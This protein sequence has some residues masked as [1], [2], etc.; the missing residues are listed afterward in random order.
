MKCIRCN[1]QEDIYFYNDRGIWYC[2]KC[3][4]FGRIN[5]GEKISKKKYIHK[6]YHCHYELDY[7]LTSYQKQVIV[8]LNRYLEK[9][10]D[11]LVY[12]ATGAGKTEIVM[13]SI[14][15]YLNQGKKVGIAISRRQV[16]L[17][18][19][20][21]MQK[22]FKELKVIA[23][24]EGHTRVTDADLI[25]CTMHQLYRYH[26]CFDLLIMDEVDAFPYRNNEVLKHIAMHACIGEVIYLSAT[27]DEEMLNDI[28]KGKL[29]V[30]K[31]FVRPHGY[32]LVVPKVM[33]KNKVI[34]WIY[35][36]QFLERN[37]KKKI[38]VLLFVPTIKL[39][40]LL[41]FYLRFRYKTTS[42]TSK[43]KN[44]E[45]ILIRF[46]QR[47]Y[48]FLICTTVLERGITIK[49][50]NVVVYQADHKIFNE[51]SLVQIIGRVGRSMEIPNGEG[52]LLCSKRNAEIMNCIESINLM[53]KN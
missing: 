43:T 2:R 20:E 37:K 42:F 17:E 24:C 35:L 7:P 48:D 50:V 32:P 1:N 51:A 22:A 44:K 16:V 27:P 29:K 14:Q 26:E 5:V 8:K 15:D 39:A 28:K 52:L 6:K 45:E 11:V 53:N 25:V 47:E 30:V 46:R 31:L 10:N 19:K 49:G 38:Q 21:R 4:G 3:V 12:A 13:Q 18:I 23:V 33:K 9:K 36:I 34:Q 40:T 41:A